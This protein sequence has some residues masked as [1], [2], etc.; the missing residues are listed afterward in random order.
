MPDFSKYPPFFLI[1]VPGLILI[2]MGILGR[3]ETKWF[4][5]ILSSLQRLAFV[6]V[7]TCLVILSISGYLTPANSSR[8]PAAVTADTR[9]KGEE[10]GAVISGTAVPVSDWQ[11]DCAYRTP[12]NGETVK[13]TTWGIFIQFAGN[14]IV[15]AELVAP[16]F[17]ATSPAISVL[18]AGYRTQDGVRAAYIKSNPDGPTPIPSR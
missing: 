15:S 3:I 6:A 10:K 8:P 17:T 4:T 2:A 12:L 18:F 16:N 14:D 5:L 9:C 13:L 11:D 7:G 1:L